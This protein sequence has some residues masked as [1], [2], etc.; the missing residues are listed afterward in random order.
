MQIAW[1][2]EECRQVERT[3]Y[4][5]GWVVHFTIQEGCGYSTRWIR[6]V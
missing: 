5:E 6:C 3:P 2:R 4:L 1:D